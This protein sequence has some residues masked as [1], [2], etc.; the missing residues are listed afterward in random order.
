MKHLVGKSLNRYR[1]VELL[2]E[3]GMGAVFRGHD[4]TLQRDVAIKVMHPHLSRKADFQERFLREAR[5]AA[6]L[7]HP[8]IV[9]V[10]DFGQADEMLFIVMEFIPGDNLHALLK[11]LRARQQWIRLDEAVHLMKQVS[12]ALDY[13]HRNGVL[14][15]DIKPANIMLKPEPVN[16]L[17]YRPILTDLGLAKLMEG[18]GLTQEGTSLGTPPYM[19]PEQAL[20]EETDGR[21][22]VYS[23]GILLY[24]LAVGQLPFPIKT[25]TDA[26]RYH[27]KETPPPPSSLYPEIPPALETVILQ[28]IAKSPADRFPDAGSLVRALEGALS[29]ATQVAPAPTALEG[30]VSL[31]TQYQA[32]LLQPRGASILEAFDSPPP[33]AETGDKLQIL[34]KDQT[35]RTVAI[36]PAGLTLG[37]GDDNDVVLDD[38]KASRHHVR[39][40]FD[41]QAYRVVDL[42]STN[43][44]LLGNA[45]LLPGVPE[46]W[47]PAAALRIGDT[48]FRLLQSAKPTSTLPASYGSTA[49]DGTAV[50]HTGGEARIGVFLET[51]QLTVEPGGSVTASL[52][53]MNQSALVDHFRLSVDGLPAAWLPAPPPPVQLMP[54]A[55]Q[56]LTFVIQP[57]KDPS[58]KAGRYP[59]TFRVASQDDPAQVAT[60][61]GTLTVGVFSQF[62]TELRPQKIRAGRSAALAVHNR[63]NAQE[64]FSVELQDRGDELFFSPA[65]AEVQVEAGGTGMIKFDVRPRA[66]KILGGSTS[67]NIAIHTASTGGVKQTMAGEVVSRALLPLWV[68]P[69]ILFLCILVSSAG[70]L[71]YQNLQTTANEATQAY[72]DGQTA[73]AQMVQSTNQAAT[74]AAQAATATANWLA[75]DSDRDGLTNREELEIYN[76]FP[77]NRDSDGDG[78][79]DGDEIERGTEPLMDDTDRDGLRDGIEINQG[80]DPLDPDTDDD[81]MNDAQDP[82]PGRPPPTETPTP[83][84]TPV[85]TITPTVTPTPTPTLNPALG[86]HQTNFDSIVIVAHGPTL[87][88]QVAC[89][90]HD[91]VLVQR[92]VGKTLNV[93]VTNFN[94][95]APAGYSSSDVLDLVLYRSLIGPWEGREGIDMWDTIE[96][97]Q[98]FGT[99]FLTFSWEVIEEGQYVL[100]LQTPVNTFYDDSFT[101]Q[102]ARYTLNQTGS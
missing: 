33:A 24:E 78:L 85:P 97:E 92:D 74:A 100:C 30:A 50:D 101:F 47:E 51:A 38:S 41:G 35:T 21:S 88:G 17:P 102:F 43:G 94:F 48:W 79:S 83:T 71:Y 95:V 91:L 5:T 54:G 22:D 73:I 32:S 46:V 60:V 29:D 49:I 80:L 15:R 77:E 87:G 3:G 82:D 57:P 89:D 4:V 42:D 67:H 58:S 13:A 19:S 56:A 84:N 9:S 76:T 11:N 31:L 75:A 28:A 2:G 72:Y 27:T 20:G 98:Y 86:S 66:R 6:R 12:A 61:K 34:S 23:L 26:I 63:G 59:L 68:P 37:R 81:G 65:Q 40:T 18:Q 8:A 14:H 36:P 55:Q 99:D 69:V 44:T 10:H 53:V 39:L 96:A 7:D 1:I 90:P 62:T 52:T 93:N 70:W 45:K 64:A 16:G 25:L